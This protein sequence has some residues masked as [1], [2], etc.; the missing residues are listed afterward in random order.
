MSAGVQEEK[1]KKSYAKADH[2]ESNL[3]HNVGSW[4]GEGGQAL[5]EGLVQ[6][7]KRRGGC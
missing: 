3:F 5:A 6:E 1:G 2:K 7:N 4:G